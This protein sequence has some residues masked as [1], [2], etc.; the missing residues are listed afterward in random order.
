MEQA[1]LSC[2]ISWYQQNSVIFVLFFY[3][4]FICWHQ[5]KIRLVTLS[6]RYLY[7]FFFWSFFHLKLTFNKTIKSA[8][9]FFNEL[10]WS[11]LTAWRNNPAYHQI[12][13]NELHEVNLL[14]VIYLK[15]IV[16][17]MMHAATNRG[18]CLNLNAYYWSFK[19]LN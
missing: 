7:K 10:N 17:I 2:H 13:S 11:N 4:F 18:W 9:N 5:R 1:L 8:R 19:S 15:Q 12:D 3:H 14:F 16:I 6:K